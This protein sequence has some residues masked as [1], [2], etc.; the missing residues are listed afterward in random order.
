MAGTPTRVN[1][2]YS[3][4]NRLLIG[5]ASQS[6][7][8][9]TDRQ[10]LRL[11][12]HMRK[13]LGLL[14]SGLTVTMAVLLAHFAGPLSGDSS[15]RPD[16]VTAPP[17]V[18]RTEATYGRIALG[19]EANRGQA[20]TRVEFL[21]RGHGYSVFLSDGEATVLLQRAGH[22]SVPSP[23]N[24]QTPGTSN[25]IQTTVLTFKLIGSKSGIHGIATDELP[26]KS[27]YFYGNDPKQ[28]IVDIPQF[29]RIRYPNAYSGIDIVYYGTQQQ[30]ESDFVVNPGSSPETITLAVEGAEKLELSAEGDLLLL[31][32]GEVIHLHKPSI[33]QDD[34]HG[35]KQIAG[36]FRIL[37]ANLFGFEVS[38]Y[39]AK[40]PLVIDPVLGYSTYLGGIGT[41]VATAVAVDA[42][43]NAYVAGATACCVPTTP[44]AFETT[45]DHNGAGFITKFS[46]SGSSLIYSTYLYTSY[47]RAIAVDAAGNVYSTGSA[48]NGFPVTP[49]AFQSSAAGNV[50]FAA[51]LN[52]AGDALV[53]GTLLGPPD[54]IGIFAETTYGKG[55][56]VDGAGNAYVTGSTLAPNF[57]T[58]PGA[59]DLTCGT[60]GNCNPDALGN[61]FQD[62]FVSKISPSGSSLVYSS[63]L[64]GSGDDLGASVAVDASGNAYVAGATVSLD[65]PVTSGAFQTTPS[66]G[67]DAFVTKLN[68]SGT[69]LAYSTF[70]AGNGDD[71]G[72]A[73][74]IDAGRNAYVA[75]STNAADFP[76]TPGSFQPF[77]SGSDG[78]PDA[79]VTKLNPT[80]A[81][82]VYSTYL[83]GSGADWAFGLVLDS[84]RNA[85]VVGSTNSLDLPLQAPFQAYC[86][87]CPNFDTSFVA[88]LNTSG[89]S[90]VYS[91][92]L[93]GGHSNGADDEGAAI[94]VDPLGNAY[95][96]GM[97]DSFDFPVVDP[98]Q[99]TMVGPDFNSDAFLAK[100][101]P[102]NADNVFLYP[103]VRTFADQ[104]VN[105]T[106]AP[107]SIDVR[108][109]GS[110]ELTVSSIAVTGDFSE[111]NDCGSGVAA[112][113][114]CN[115]NVSFA[116][117][118]AGTRTGLMILTDSAPG[119]PHSVALTGVGIIAPLLS[120]SSFSLDFGNQNVGTSS[121]AQ[122]ET[123]SNVGSAILNISSIFVPPPF[124]LASTT[125]G[126]SIA[127]G[128]SCALAV[129]FS[130]LQTGL[131]FG[132]L[133][134][135]DDDA[136]GPHVVT[137]TG[138]GTA[139]APPDFA[140]SVTPPSS[141]I[142]AGATA[143]YTLTLTP[144][145]GF[146]QNIA[147]T[148]SGAPASSSCTVS[149]STVNLD[150]INAS[151]AD[152]S[153]S[154]TS[155]SDALASGTLPQ[156]PVGPFLWTSGILPLMWLMAWRKPLRLPSHAQ[157][158]MAVGVLA[159]L[160][161]L[162]TAC[163]GG[164][165][166]PPT[167]HHGTPPGTYNVSVTGT[168]PGVSSH[169]ITFKL[170]VQ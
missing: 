54:Q 142:V 95:V 21:S 72:N 78:G 151:T 105:S 17:P 139:G 116:P 107:M 33:Y 119:S 71:W 132:Q 31:T 9:P 69:A 82:L 169:T 117:T 38:S 5:L 41:D 140:L 110:V 84:T 23:P 97:T 102:G 113:G 62:G 75:G 61:P 153:I 11:G 93:G 22:L 111:T 24:S 135:T 165:S 85:Y 154:T 123:L 148:C 80:G 47:I 145:G 138:T 162:N 53:Y 56:A 1:S 57:P 15:T 70:L 32:V 51:K 63:Y 7:P 73:I 46:P 147:L 64:G 112:G 159:L 59:F 14:A 10:R 168:S 55:I 161:V 74:A 2:E 35:R 65:F 146:D 42:S 96:V 150:G 28:W 36:G 52:P 43:G 4:R 114:I 127:P 39:N 12:A 37:G 103:P 20:D 79:F 90:L 40:L 27:N 99:S 101:G 26:G 91:S 128:Q 149:P 98:F 94:A 158:G 141:M 13:R 19:F 120:L 25:P 136:I 160:L 106:S 143:T 45:P 87:T 48:A 126:N 131:F 18:K 144:S 88:E 104:P 125:C 163:G 8:G 81:T 109:M 83:G 170:I 122:T 124:Q 29:G 166:G 76:T 133:V 92:Y 77:L 16:L 167:A 89:S 6:N 44:G 30:L 115:V 68:A 100:I 134:V 118:G 60:D 137:L 66:A 130:P 86:L 108:N 155:R 157:I 67:V 164:S 58:T 34:D 152:V 3:G 121:S 129:T 49:G 156:P 50:A